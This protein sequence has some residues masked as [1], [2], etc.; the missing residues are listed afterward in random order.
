MSRTPYEDGLA[1]RWTYRSLFNDSDASKPFN[2]LRFGF[3]TLEIDPAPRGVFRGRLIGPGVTF[4]VEGSVGDARP[5]V[6]RFQL[7]G[8]F[9]SEE[10]LYDYLG[11]VIPP[12]P[13][14]VGQL[15]TML[16]TLVRDIPYTD[17]GGGLAA[18]GLVAT[19]F[20]V[21]EGELPD[22]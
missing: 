11:W 16:G 15:P 5:R 19:W 1:G 6:L 21:R 8:I 13:Q 12:W 9:H 2:D 18:A 22:R 14:G 7:R 17:T 10:W 20:A 4:R 3:G